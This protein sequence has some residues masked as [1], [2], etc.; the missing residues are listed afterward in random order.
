[1]IDVTLIGSVRRR[2]VLTRA[3]GAPGHL[4][5][6]TGALGGFAA[7]VKAPRGAAPSFEGPKSVTLLQMS[8]EI[9]ANRAASACMDLSD[10]LA[11]AVTQLATA[12]GTGAVVSSSKV[13][14]ATDATLEDALRGGEDYEL[15]FAVPPKRRRAFEKI[16]GRWAAVTPVG[17][18]TKIQSLQLDDAPLGGG[19]AHF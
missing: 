16:A 2:R 9:A 15:L 11:D 1:V 6:V 12:S 8:R 5:Y 13:P 19:F 10:G 18:L 7:F 17:E 14:V 4:L 3:G